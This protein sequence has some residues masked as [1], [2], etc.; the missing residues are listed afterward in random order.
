[1]KVYS[2]SGC[3]LMGQVG[4]YEGMLWECVWFGGA[5]RAL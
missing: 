2:G 3:S 1:V 5:G 4:H